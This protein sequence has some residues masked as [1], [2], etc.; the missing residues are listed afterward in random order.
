MTDRRYEAVVFDLDGTLLDT[1]QDIANAMNNVLKRHGFPE[2][3]IAS[4]RHFIGNGISKLVYRALPSE[5]SESAHYNKLLSEV[6]DE[7]SRHLDVYT[8]LYD[9]IEG[10]L[11]ELTKRGIRLA[12]LSNKDDSFMDE[13]V[14]TY[15]S[16]WNFEVVFGARVNIPVKPDPYS[17]LEI[18]EIM[19]LQPAEFIFLGDSNVDM[20]T[21]NRAGMYAL[22]AAWGFRGREELYANGAQAVIDSPTDLLT[23]L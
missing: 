22:G 18:A 9:G 6:I 10:L 20:H 15:L 16:Q 23:L 11:T 13:V 21:A 5:I 8:K 14:A 4:Y 12:I 7:Y 17:A 2:H 1:V 19:G 3:D